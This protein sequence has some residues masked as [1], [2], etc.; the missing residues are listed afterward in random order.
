MFADGEYYLREL[1]QC[2]HRWKLCWVL[3]VES[4]RFKEGLLYNI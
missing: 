2:C 1:K 3:L 4:W